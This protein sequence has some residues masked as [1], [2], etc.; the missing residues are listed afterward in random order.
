MVSHVARL[1]PGQKVH[2]I[3]P[4]TGSVVIRGEG[5]EGA[6]CATLIKAFTDTLGFVDQAMNHEETTYE[7]LEQE[8]REWQ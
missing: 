2:F 8:E 6:T 5:F 7:Y 4:R 3:F 1:L